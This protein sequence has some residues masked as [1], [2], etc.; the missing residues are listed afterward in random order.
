MPNLFRAKLIEKKALTSSIFWCV[1]EVIEP[2]NFTYTPGQFVHIDIPTAEGKIVRRSYS[3]CS[4]NVETGRF[5]LCVKIVEG[6]TGSVFLNSLTA[7]DEINGEAPLGHFVVK[8]K[9][10]PIVFV[11]TGTGIAPFR[12]MLADAP[13]A[14]VWFGN[15][16][17]E[18]LFWMEDLESRAAQFHVTLSQPSDTWTGLRGRVTAHTNVIVHENPSTHY[19]LCGTPP[20]VLEMR[21]ALIA[22]DISPTNIFFELFT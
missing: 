1:F 4:G 17:E 10:V 12:A 21:K 19:Y 15:R 20:M 5:E 18:D 16:G 14:T 6:G 2:A 3:I 11:A 9:T 7:G 13:H 8:D 22:S